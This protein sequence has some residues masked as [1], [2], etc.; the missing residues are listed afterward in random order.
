[1]ALE[2]AKSGAEDARD[3]ALRQVQHLQHELTHAQ[4]TAA[5]HEREMLQVTLR[6][7]LSQLKFTAN[8]VL[9]VVI[10]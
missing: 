2:E 1:M 9:T 7:S 6:D 5:K 8:E 3:E 10:Q 4:S